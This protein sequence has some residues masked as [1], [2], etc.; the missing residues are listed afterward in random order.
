MTTDLALGA[1][2]VV[3]ILAGL[4]GTVVPVVPG[5]VV[6]WLATAGT[7]LAQGRG[8]LAWVVVAVLTGLM[9]TGT[10]LSTV[11][12]ARRAAASGAPRR[13]LSLAAAGAIVGFF[14]IPVLGLLIGGVAGLMLAEHD[15]LGEWAPAWRSAKGVMAAYGWGV[16]L[17]ILVGVLMGLT[18]LT[19]FVL[20]AV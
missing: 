17:E 8:P 10:V 12:P 6:V 9:L 7:L 1:V 13:S 15:R 4:V 20:R 18:W 3:G 14:V 2:G 16:L 5:L 19:T 11:L